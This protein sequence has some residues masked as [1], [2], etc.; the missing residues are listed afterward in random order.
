MVTHVEVETERPIHRNRQWR[1]SRTWLSFSVNSA[2]CSNNIA[3]ETQ[4]KIE[5]TMKYAAIFLAVVS[6]FS[7][8][9]FSPGKSSTECLVIFVIFFVWT[10][11]SSLLTADE[12]PQLWLSSLL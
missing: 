12:D 2:T 8:E 5:S 9:A 7:A 1:E 6:I 10:S 4:Q 3:P 11:D